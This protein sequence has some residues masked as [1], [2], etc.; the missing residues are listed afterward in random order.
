MNFSTLFSDAYFRNLSIMTGVFALF[1]ILLIPAYFL[2]LRPSKGTTE[3]MQRIDQPEFEP[4]LCSKLRWGD[5]PFAL[6]AGVCAA[7]LRMV[8]FLCIY[9]DRGVLI[10]MHEVLP[11]LTVHY[12]LPCAILGIAVYLL[13]RSMFETALPATCVA[14]LSG[15]VQIGNAWMAAV[16]MVILLLLWLWISLDADSGLF[17]RAL[18][19]IGAVSLYCLALLRY[20]ALIWLL[21]LFIGA[22]I[23]AQIYRWRKTTRKDRGVRLGLSLLFIFFM[24]VLALAGAWIFYCLSRM[25]DTS[26]ILNIPLALNT[27]MQGVADRLTGIHFNNYPFAGVLARDAIFFLL[28]VVSII[29]ILHGLFHWHDGQCFVLLA[30]I[31]VFVAIWLLGNAYLF[32]PMITL[33][34]GWVL[35]VIAKREYSWVV[36]TFCVVPAATF[37]LEHFI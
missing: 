23:Y 17:V 26:S 28:G 20:W 25:D 13:L 30:L 5:L 37:L 33:L 2:S 6:L 10:V 36:I 12:L 27:V 32:V 9:L 3:W 34:F 16:T 4:L 14:I 15:L 29:P 11:S 24:A 7:V 21:P 35:S 22:Y 8:S 31:P 19:L 1:A 18:A